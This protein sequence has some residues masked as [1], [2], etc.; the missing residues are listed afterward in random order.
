MRRT[1]CAVAMSADDARA[2]LPN[3]LRRR[4]R[5]DTSRVSGTDNGVGDGGESAD[6]TVVTDLNGRPAVPGWRVASAGI[7]GVDSRFSSRLLVEGSSMAEWV[8][9]PFIR[10]SSSARFGRRRRRGDLDTAGTSSITR[11]RGAAEFPWSLSAALRR[12]GD[13]SLGRALRSPTFRRLVKGGRDDDVSTRGFTSPRQLAPPRMPASL[14]PAQRQRARGGGRATLLPQ[15]PGSTT[16]P[17]PTAAAE[18]KGEGAVNFG[19]HVPTGCPQAGRC[20]AN[21]AN[22]GGRFLFGG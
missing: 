5:S 11:G 2:E 3:A 19:E 4:R 8:L 20:V 12:P 7:G 13:R 14:D 16:P 9:L 17:C 15:A 10:P 21:A 22:A 18:D 6:S 1:S